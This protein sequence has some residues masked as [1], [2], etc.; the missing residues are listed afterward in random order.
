M[1]FCKDRHFEIVNLRQVF[2][3]IRHN[4]YVR[5][6]F[7]HELPESVIHP[8]ETVFF[9]QLEIGIFPASLIYVPRIDYPGHDS[10]PLLIEL[11]L[12]PAVLISEEPHGS[13]VGLS[14]HLLRPV[15]R[16][17]RV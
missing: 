3:D 9:G 4:L 7:G 12:R 17:V 11:I 13:H 2:E 8:F 5:Y 1:I 14:G 15:Q 10:F 6:D 16:V